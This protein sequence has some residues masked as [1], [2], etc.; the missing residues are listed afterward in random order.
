MQQVVAS[1]PAIARAVRCL[2]LYDQLDLTLELLRQCDWPEFE[3]RED[4]PPNV[5]PFRRR[6]G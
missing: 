3:Q 6:R 5:I 4:L 2:S 1:Q